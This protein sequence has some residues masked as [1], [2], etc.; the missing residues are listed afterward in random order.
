MI[1]NSENEKLLT[2]AV[3]RTI[4]DSLSDRNQMSLLDSALEQNEID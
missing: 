1:H 2:I 3:K 4:F